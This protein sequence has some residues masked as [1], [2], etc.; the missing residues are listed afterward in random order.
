MS[1]TSINEIKPTEY[2]TIRSNEGGIKQAPCTKQVAGITSDGHILSSDEND[3][4]ITYPLDMAN[5]IGT[6]S[7]F[8]PDIGSYTVVHE[9]SK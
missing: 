7:V 2:V 3:R 4:G 1:I 6:V 5:Y 8:S 9:F